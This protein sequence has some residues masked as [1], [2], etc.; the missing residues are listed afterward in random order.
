MGTLARF[1][2]FFVSELRGA[3]QRKKGGASGY[4]HPAGPVVPAGNGAPAAGAGGDHLRAELQSGPVASVQS[5]QHHAG[6]DT[7][8]FTNP[9]NAAIAQAARTRH[10]SLHAGVD[11]ARSSGSGTVEELKQRARTIYSQQD[12]VHG[13]PAPS[14]VAAAARMSSASPAKGRTNSVAI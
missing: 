14:P 12:G 6:S 4:E 8:G 10:D 7:F 13:P 3:V 11:S 1:A 5:Q 2:Q 9:M